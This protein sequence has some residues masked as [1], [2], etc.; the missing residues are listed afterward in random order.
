[1][2]LIV[3]LYALGCCGGG[4][5]ALPAWVRHLTDS[6]TTIRLTS[7]H[8]RQVDL[9]QRLGHRPAGTWRTELISRIPTNQVFQLHVQQKVVQLPRLSRALDGLTITHL[10]DLHFTGQITR[11]FY[12]LTV[13]EAN[14]LD[15]DLVVITGDI[16]DRQECLPWIPELLGRLRSHHGMFFVLGNH[17]LRIRDEVGLRSELRRAGLIDLGGAGN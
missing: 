10:S 5:A 6:G 2:Q 3:G 15:A 13:E 17:D 9:M 11:P 8:T 1:M 7:N 16:I 4:I 14:A 12:E